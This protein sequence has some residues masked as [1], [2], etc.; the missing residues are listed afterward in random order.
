MSKKISNQEI[1]KYADA[2][3]ISIKDDELEFI[4]TKIKKAC[5][6]ANELEYI[7]TFKDVEFPSHNYIDRLHNDEFVKYD[8]DK[9]LS[10]SENKENDFIVIKNKNGKI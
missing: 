7:D 4:T 5:E 1:I 2:I 6:S 8:K 9:I 10:C 3:G